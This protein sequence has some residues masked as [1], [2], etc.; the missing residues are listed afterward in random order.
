ML[1]YR[2]ELKWETPIWHNTNTAPGSLR[3]IHQR[4]G[5]PA[6][7]VLLRSVKRPWSLLHLQRISS[8]LA[9]GNVSEWRSFSVLRYGIAI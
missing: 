3:L 7:M 1:K 2:K 9:H 4:E 6:A 8:A 5:L